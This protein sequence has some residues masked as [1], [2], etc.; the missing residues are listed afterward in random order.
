MNPKIIAL[1]IIPFL[2]SAAIKAQPLQTVPNVD[3]KKYAGKWFEIA[4][5]P[6]RFQKG[7]H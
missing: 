2:M 4:S 5:F 3:F 6:Q 7:C 1:F